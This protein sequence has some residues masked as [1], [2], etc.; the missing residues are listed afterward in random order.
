MSKALTKKVGANDESDYE[1]GQTFGGPDLVYYLV[2]HTE[3]S[4]PFRTPGPPI[5][6]QSIYKV[7][8]CG[9][10]EA[11]LSEVYYQAGNFGISTVFCCAFKEGA[12][13]MKAKMFRRVQDVE[14][15]G[16]PVKIQG[17]V[18]VFY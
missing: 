15:L 7:L 1:G 8:R 3:Q 16:M 11:A 5:E 18:K 4:Q 12:D 13:I 10:R 6:G 9:S 17:R 2:L 14:N